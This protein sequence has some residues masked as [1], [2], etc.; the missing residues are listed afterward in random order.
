MSQVFMPR[1]DVVTTPNRVKRGQMIAVQALISDSKTGMFMPFDKIYMQILDEKGIEIWP[2]ST[3]AE[4]TERINKLIS[5]SQM[6]PGKYLIRI[7]PSKKLRPMGVSYFHIESSMLDMAVPLI[8]P[9]LLAVTSSTKKEKITADFFSPTTAINITWALYQTEK[10]SRV[11]PICLNYAGRIYRPD[12]PT[13]PRIG[14][15]EL[16]GDTHW[17]C[18]CHY[19]FITREMEMQQL[20]AQY[21]E[22]KEIFE[23]AQVAMVAQQVFNQK[24]SIG[25]WR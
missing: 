19:D 13:M 20:N 12:D 24:R 5:T 4:G 9:V 8:P 3:I 2:L 14:P 16:G 18:R 11:C 21:E 23:V 15:E 22:M 7:S 6:K 25:K 17:G 1:V 10:D